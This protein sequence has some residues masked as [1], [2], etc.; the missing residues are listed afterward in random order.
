[1]V[2]PALNRLDKVA[3]SIPPAASI[4]G[5]HESSRAL[6]RRNHLLSWTGELYGRAGVMRLNAGDRP[7]AAALIAKGERL[8]PHDPA[9]NSGLANLAISA[10]DVAAAEQPMRNMLAANPR[11]TATRITLARILMNLHRWKDA[12]AELTV[13]IGQTPHDASL[14]MLSAMT[15]MRNNDD[16]GAADVLKDGLESG[17][18]ARNSVQAWLLS[19]GK[20]GMLK[21]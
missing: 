8:S 20:S 2:E 5:E 21:Q 13:C 6:T 17:V 14:Y 7:K 15:R 11:D 3:A 1:M 10:N 9:V 4:G 16:D 12:D 19:V 18:L